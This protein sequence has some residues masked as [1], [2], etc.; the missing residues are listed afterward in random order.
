MTNLT[1]IQKHPLE[2][3]TKEEKETDYS[4]SDNHYIRCLK[5]MEEIMDLDAYILDYLHEKIIYLT[6]NSSFRWMLKNYQEEPVGYDLLNKIIPEEDLQKVQQ[7][8]RLGFDFYFQLPVERRYHGAASLD[9]RIKNPDGEYTLINHKISVL[10]MTT[11]GRIR[12]G[13]CVLNYPTSKTPGKTYFKMTDTNQIYEY[14][15][16]SGKFVEVK[17]QRLTPK[18]EKVLELASQG[19]TEPEIAQTLH[20]SLNTVKYHK[21]RIFKQLGVRNTTEAVQWINSQKKLVDKN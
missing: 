11:D 1:F 19:K 16:K 14:I 5:A 2:Y 15:E 3:F 13:L 4:D 18:S 8:N 9:I 7:V 6:K 17:T 20:F 21:Q 10:D 12:L